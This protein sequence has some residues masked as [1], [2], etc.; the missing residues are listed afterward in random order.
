[1]LCQA[2]NVIKSVVSACL[3]IK[4]IEA[5]YR[6]HEIENGCMIGDSCDALHF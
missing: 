1:M 5:E 3:I 4:A 2:S 6:L